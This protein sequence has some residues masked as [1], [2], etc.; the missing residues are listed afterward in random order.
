MPSFRTGD[1]LTLTTGA[2]PGSTLVTADVY[3]ATQLPEC[4]PLTCFLF[5]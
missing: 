1:T 4:S 2:I 3:I 5:W